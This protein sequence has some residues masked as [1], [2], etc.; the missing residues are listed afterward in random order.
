MSLL[1]NTT[2]SFSKEELHTIAFE[3]R[4]DYENLPDAKDSFARELIVH[5]QRRKRLHELM[6]VL[7]RERPD[8]TW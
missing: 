7:R 4:V 6:E 1:K 8:G 5:L 2:D 3:L